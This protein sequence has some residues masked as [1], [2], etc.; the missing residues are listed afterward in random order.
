MTGRTP[1][2]NTFGMS[3]RNATT[4]VRA[5]RLTSSVYACLYH[6]GTFGGLRRKTL[7][8]RVD[9]AVASRTSLDDLIHNFSHIRQTIHVLH[10]VLTPSDAPPQPATTTTAK[11]QKAT[12]WVNATELAEAALSTGMRKVFAAVQ[13]KPKGG[14]TKK[15]AVE[16][17]PAG[18]RSKS[19]TSVVGQKRKAMVAAGAAAKQRTLFDMLGGGG[20][21]KEGVKRE[22]IAVEVEDD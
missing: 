4:C 8:L 18:S 10:W 1:S 14:A 21:S 11:T 15:S 9:G 20:K 17:S 2:C 7:G 22:P 12:R 3:P 16:A 5:S 6:D 19:E 13:Q